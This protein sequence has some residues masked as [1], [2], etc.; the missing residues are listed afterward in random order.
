[1]H[2]DPIF[3]ILFYILIGLAMLTDWI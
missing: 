2:T 1:M 3:V